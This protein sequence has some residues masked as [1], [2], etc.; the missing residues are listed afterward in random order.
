[1]WEPEEI[2]LVEAA[3]F[4]EERTGKPDRLKHAIWRALKEGVLSYRWWNENKN[5]WGQWVLDHWWDDPDCITH[6]LENAD[7]SGHFL[8]PK[9]EIDRLWPPSETG[10]GHSR[11]GKGGRPQEHNWDGAF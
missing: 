7:R 3:R 5:E 1:M 4:V 11:R 6:I 10:G 2:S 8:V 9:A